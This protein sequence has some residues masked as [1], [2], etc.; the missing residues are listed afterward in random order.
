MTRFRIHGGADAGAYVS[1]SHIHRAA[2]T[3]VCR[4]VV[5]SFSSASVAE[6]LAGR[7]VCRSS[8]R[9]RPQQRVRDRCKGRLDGASS[10]SITGSVLLLRQGESQSGL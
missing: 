4:H 3:S 7:G 2:A 6:I 1:P 8:R 10:M 9:A 5:V